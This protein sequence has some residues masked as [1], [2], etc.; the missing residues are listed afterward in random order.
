MRRVGG[1]AGHSG[2]FSGVERQT[3][4]PVALL[5]T[6]TQGLGEREGK[7]GKWKAQTSQHTLGKAF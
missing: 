3:H 1:A 6:F 2:Q 4:V 7:R 5:I